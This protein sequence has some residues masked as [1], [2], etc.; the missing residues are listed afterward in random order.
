MLLEGQKA[1]RRRVMKPRVQETTT[2]RATRLVTKGC[3]AR[4]AEAE[5]F[6]RTIPRLT[7]TAR[8]RRG[9][10]RESDS[11]LDIG[12]YVAIGGQ[13]GRLYQRDKRIVADFALA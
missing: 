10:R 1:P 8:Q 2:E 5:R 4:D 9:L 3:A 6:R 13:V 7:D 12:L 11:P